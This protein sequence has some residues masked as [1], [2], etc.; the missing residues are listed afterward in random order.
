M[1]LTFFRWRLTID[2]YEG[3]EIDTDGELLVAQELI[4]HVSSLGASS[5][6]NLDKCNANCRELGR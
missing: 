1:K 3:F 5:L 4:E 2:R 6:V